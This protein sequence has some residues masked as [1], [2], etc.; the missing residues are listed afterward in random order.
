MFRPGPDLLFIRR[1]T[2]DGDPWS[3]HMAF[4][5]GRQDPGDDTLLHT[6]MRETQEEVGI[7]LGGAEHIG[8]V[9]DL[10]TPAQVP[11]RLVIAGFAFSLDHDPVV[12]TNYE[13]ADVH[14]FSLERLMN[15]EGRGTFERTRFDR[16]YTFPCLRLDGTMI[17]GLTLRIL[18]N[19]LDRIRRGGEAN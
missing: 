14:W 1:S 12:E 18:D 4:P 8:R 2:R 6:A 15:R 11:I 9:D 10:P 17:W 5:G 3:G 19:T 7:D 13:V 16:N